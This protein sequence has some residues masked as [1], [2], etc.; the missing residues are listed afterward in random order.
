V[1]LRGRTCSE[2]TS[3]I[4]VRSA[5]APRKSGLS[6]DEAEWVETGVFEQL[7][8]DPRAAAEFLYYLSPAGR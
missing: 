8:L 1:A 3:P 5:S 4:P 6:H 7:A 2:P